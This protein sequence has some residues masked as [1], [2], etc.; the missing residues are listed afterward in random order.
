MA[1]LP[2][3]CAP[4]TAVTSEVAAITMSKWALLL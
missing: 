1:A 3:R 2:D 4:A